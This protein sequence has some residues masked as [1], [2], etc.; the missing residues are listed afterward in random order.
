MTTILAVAQ[1]AD[2]GSSPL[3]TF[4]LPFVLVIG[5]FYFLIIRP[6]RKRESKRQDMIEALEKG[7]KIVTVGGVHGTIR[8]VDDDSVLA[9]VDSNV[10]LRFDKNSIANAP[11]KEDE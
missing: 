2:G 4:I 9:E 8:R 11:N 1:A 5:V 3:I 10:K 7:D 6:Q